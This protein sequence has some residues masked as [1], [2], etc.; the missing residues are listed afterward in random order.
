MYNWI[1]DTL[2][3]MKRSGARW[4]IDL[5]QEEI[6][7]GFLNNVLRDI[8]SGHLDYSKYGWVLFEEP[9]MNES[10]AA[11]CNKSKDL[12]YKL[13]ALS[14]FV[15]RVKRGE[16]VD[17]YGILPE[18]EI[19]KHD[20]NILGIYS[21]AVENYRLYQNKEE[22]ILCMDDITTEGK[23][24]KIIKDTVEV[25]NKPHELTWMQY[26]TMSAG[27]VDK[28]LR[29]LAK[30]KTPIQ[31]S[32]DTVKKFPNIVA[33]AIRTATT[34]MYLYSAMET[35]ISEILKHNP[36]DQGFVMFLYPQIKRSQSAYSIA[37]EGLQ[38]IVGVPVDNF[39]FKP[40]M[41]SLRERLKDYNGAL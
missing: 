39:M 32:I 20:Y 6:Q 9:F 29:G 23:M 5:G 34:R 1:E 18:Y 21:K 8:E 38:N 7:R 15:D 36:Q 28:F 13:W 11:A 3:K 24:K 40:N 10:Y 14:F 16:E 35:G 30:G 22:F 31:D 4:L 25:N 27:C 26:R 19:I 37:L 33:A 12:Y 2:N 41:I 17:Y